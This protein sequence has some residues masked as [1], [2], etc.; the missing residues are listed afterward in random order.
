M[1]CS[2]SD[3]PWDPLVQWS[4]A[5]LLVTLLLRHGFF[6]WD[7]FKNITIACLFFEYVKHN[8]ILKVKIMQKEVATHLYPFYSYSS[9]FPGLCIHSQSHQFFFFSSSS[10][11]VCCT[12]E[13]LHVYSSYFSFFLSWQDSIIWVLFL[14][15][16][17]QWHLLGFL[18]WY[19]CFSLVPVDGGCFITQDVTAATMISTHF[20]PSSPLLRISY[21]CV[22]CT[23][24]TEI[25]QDS[26]QRR[27]SWPF[28]L[29]EQLIILLK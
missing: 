21:P 20:L 13:Q 8:I 16:T 9:S 1:P 12:N 26:G 3:G 14:V 28:F 22:Q 24:D 2:A 27:S 11:C 23:Q 29:T 5:T 15:G 19:Y 25:S 7:S 6:C 4:L 17:K 10:L 18:C